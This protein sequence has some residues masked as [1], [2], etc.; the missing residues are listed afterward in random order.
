VGKKATYGS[1]NWVAFWEVWDFSVI[2]SFFLIQWKCNT[3]HWSTPL[4]LS[5]GFSDE[6]EEL[7][8]VFS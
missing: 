8:T 4:S 6:E 1:R 5:Y 7:M 2:F 3:D